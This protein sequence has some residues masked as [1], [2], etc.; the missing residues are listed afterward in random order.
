MYYVLRD[1]DFFFFGNG[2]G[3]GG[4]HGEKHVNVPALSL[5]LTPT[6]IKVHSTRIVYS[7][8]FKRL[9][10]NKDGRLIAVRL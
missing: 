4:L 3:G 10:L 7:A 1:F 8:L 5:S 2:A 6:Q 9:L